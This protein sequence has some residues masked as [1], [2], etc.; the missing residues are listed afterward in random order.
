MTDHEHTEFG[1]FMPFVITEPNGPFDAAAF[2]AGANAT[3][4]QLKMQMARA[5]GLDVRPAYVDPRILPQLDLFAMQYRFV[6]KQ[7]ETEDLTWVY[8]QFVREEDVEHD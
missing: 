4:F 3:D 6:L 8:V 2:V 7:E 1:G 5:F